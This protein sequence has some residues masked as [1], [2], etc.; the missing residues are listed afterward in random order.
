MAEPA[1]KSEYV[2]GVDIGGTKIYAG[3]FNSSL[4]CVG[5]ARVSTKA[6]RGPE[7]VIDRILRCI[8]DAIDG[9]DRA[10]KVGL[11]LSRRGTLLVVAVLLYTAIRWFTG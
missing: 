9:K 11:L 8:S 6:Q 1:S 2:V 10:G 4:E 5:T 7:S 3:V